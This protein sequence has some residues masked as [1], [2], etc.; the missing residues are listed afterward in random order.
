MFKMKLAKKVNFVILFPNLKKK[1]KI[2]RLTI[3]YPRRNLI[4]TLMTQI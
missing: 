4:K 1:V 3:F 2:S